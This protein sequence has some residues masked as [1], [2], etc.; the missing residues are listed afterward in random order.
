[1]KNVKTV[2]FCQECGY[3]SPKW[4]GRCPACG[5]WNCFV[6]EEAGGRESSDSAGERGYGSEPVSIDAIDAVEADRFK[7][8]IGEF[9]RVVGGGLVAGATI[10]IGGDPGIGKSTLLMQVLQRIA[11]AGL[12]TLYISGEESSRQIKIRGTRI[13]ALSPNLIVLVEVSLDAIIKRIDEL[14]PAVVVVDSIQTMYSDVYTSA[15]GSVTQVREAS[16]KLIV[17][18]KKTGVPLFLIGHV[19]KDG[20]I[21]GP[22]VLEHMVDTVLYFEGDSGHDF[23]I[24]RA[25]KNRFGPTNEIGV[26]EMGEQGL[27]EVENPSALFLS[28]R[29][30]GAAGSVVTASMEG[31][32]PILV[33]VQSLVSETNFGIPR[34]TTIGVEHN[35]VSLLAAVLDR[36][37]GFNLSGFDIFVNVAGGVRLGE[38]AVDLAVVSSL[39]SSFLKRPVDSGTLVFGEVGLTG[40]VRGVG[41]VHAR[42]REA[43]RMG[44]NRCMTPESAVESAAFIDGVT[45]V[46]V[47]TIGE[48]IERLF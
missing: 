42:V 15:P 7:T 38:P 22:R 23:R 43:G 13:G 46:G 8:G 1:M 3:R 5:S 21:A 33:E 14:K 32:R 28:E 48:L 18:A 24:I 20:S 29:P 31:T 45:I 6:E 27:A 26:F 25:V 16:E 11:D 9:D 41:Q 10:L 37:C 2:F 4:L 47:S 35:R 30:G 39:A 34:R 36:V 12:K 19:T 17:L 44:F 40:E